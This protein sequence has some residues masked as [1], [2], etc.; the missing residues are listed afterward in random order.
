MEEVICKK[1]EVLSFQRLCSDGQSVTVI[2]DDFNRKCHSSL[3]RTV[4]ALQACAKII[5]GNLPDSDFEENGR[6]QNKFCWGKALYHT[7]S[8]ASDSDIILWDDDSVAI[9]AFDKL[10][11]IRTRQRVF[12]Q[13]VFMFLENK[14][15]LST[16]QYTNASLLLLGINETFTS[17]TSAALFEIFFNREKNARLRVRAEKYFEGKMLERES[18]LYVLFTTSVIFMTQYTNTS[19]AKDGLVELYR[20]AAIQCKDVIGAIMCVS[21]RESLKLDRPKALP[22]AKHVCRQLSNLLSSKEKVLLN[23][24]TR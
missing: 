12:S 4:N 10:Y 9:D 17:L 13:A 16:Q 14:K 22:I 21:V 24:L 11:G 5:S 1:G 3:I 6:E 15:I 23:I 8:I 19:R 18:L 2:N 20:C 7:M